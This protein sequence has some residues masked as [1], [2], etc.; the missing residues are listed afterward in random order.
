MGKYDLDNYEYDAYL[1]QKGKY[2]ELRERHL[3]RRNANK[4][5]RGWHFGLGDKPV[6][7]RDKEEFKRELDKRGLMMIDDVKKDLRS[8]KRR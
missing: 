6:Y 1:A 2:K 5:Y 8:P 3:A 4:G 7:T